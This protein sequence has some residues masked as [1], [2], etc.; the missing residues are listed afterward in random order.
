MTMEAQF[1]ALCPMHWTLC[2]ELDGAEFDLVK[3]AVLLNY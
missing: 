1:G 2:A 3:Q